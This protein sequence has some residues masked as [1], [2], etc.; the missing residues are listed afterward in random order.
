MSDFP[1][2]FDQ[3]A[4]PVAE[5]AKN[6]ACEACQRC[7][8]K[9]E[10]ISALRS[11]VVWLRKCDAAHI[12]AARRKGEHLGR[13]FEAAFVLLDDPRG[14][15]CG[16]NGG[17]DCGWCVRAKELRSAMANPQSNNHPNVG[18]GNSKA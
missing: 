18:C 3:T 14:C 5:V 1:S 7:R 10:T 9:D 6:M 8:V 13:I 16:N 4:K 15:T 2:S 17:S 12:D 11:Q